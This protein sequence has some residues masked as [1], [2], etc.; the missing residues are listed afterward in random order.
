MLKP[1]IDLYGDSAQY[2]RGSIG[3]Q[4]TNGEWSKQ[5]CR[6]FWNRWFGS[7]SR[8][9]LHYASLAE[10]AGVDQLSLS[11]ELVNVSPQADHWR[12]LIR[13]V[14][15]VYRGTVTDAA[16]WGYLNAT[17]GEVF[18]KTWW[19]AVD[20]IGVDAYWPIAGESHKAKLDSWRPIVDRLAALSLS[21]GEKPIL[22]TEIGY[23]A[24]DCSDTARAAS[25]SNLEWQRSSYEAAWDAF[26]SRSWF[27][28]MY[29]W[30]WNTDP[31]GSASPSCITPQ[32]KPA[33]RLLHRLYRGR[34]EWKPPPK[35]WTPV[36][37]CTV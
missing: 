15:R 33:E 7:Y 10:A 6:H 17:G 9:L 24:R 32:G 16:N 5:R 31:A 18:N 36:C 34:G 14:R 29:W 30:A 37:T 4:C 1:H 2:W 20:L 23:C 27:R 11:C 28:G 8:F 22:L 25:D 3:V 13:N 26:S 19:D 21:W 12:R 35:T